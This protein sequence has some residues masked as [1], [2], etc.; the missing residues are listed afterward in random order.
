MTLDLLLIHNGGTNG[1][2]DASKILRDPAFLN[3]FDRV[4]IFHPNLH[5]YIEYRNKDF[6][7][8][9]KEVKCK[10][11][12]EIY[13]EIGTPQIIINGYDDIWLKDKLKEWKENGAKIIY[14]YHGI[15][16]VKNWF[17]SAYVSAY[18]YRNPQNNKLDLYL[19]INRYKKGYWDPSI[20]IRTLSI[21]NNNSTEALGS[22]D[23]RWGDTLRNSPEYTKGIWYYEKPWREWL[24]SMVESIQQSDIIV[25]PSE[26]AKH[27]INSILG[28]YNI[29]IQSEVIPHYVEFTYDSQLV[30]EFK[31]SLREELEKSN[32]ELI[33][34][35]SGRRAM[36]KGV[37]ETLD[38][39]ETLHTRGYKVLLLING[40]DNIDSA[41]S[42]FIDY[43]GTNAEGYSAPHLPA[44][45][46]IITTNVPKK[47]LGDI[48]KKYPYKQ[49]F[50]IINS[51]YKALGDL[52]KEGYN[53]VFSGISRDEQ[54][55][56][57]HAKMI[58]A[59][60]PIIYRGDNAVGELVKDCD[61]KFD[62]LNYD[63]EEWK[64]CPYQLR[65]TNMTAR[66]FE[67]ILEDR[68]KLQPLQYVN[69]TSKHNYVQQWKSIIDKMQ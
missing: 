48:A 28:A 43:Q 30:D 5:K 68:L 65:I 11:W 3:N 13:K 66:L 38:T 53:I 44:M 69:S 34:V 29:K 25:A 35:L 26:S 60:V 19:E 36:E 61:K 2:Y 46:R 6:E 31:D 52:F 20:L 37:I 39:L 32:A 45:Q 42:E 58:L 62:V 24:D 8:P 18:L 59:G 23:L 49:P 7:E 21:L 22:G 64:V 33:V 51:Y 67:E 17:N 16:P 63:K 14:H 40:I 56:M 4:G 54:F 10:D 47:D 9:F 15:V 12:N 57:V 41:E 55:G 27:Q 50:E 1:I